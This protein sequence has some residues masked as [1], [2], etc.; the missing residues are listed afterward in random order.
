[1]RHFIRNLVG[2]AAMVCL[3]PSA[4]ALV[5]NF[6]DLSGSDFFTA[7]YQGFTFAAY[8]ADR[9][10]PCPQC[11]GSWFWSDANPEPVSFASS[12]NTSL[13]TDY[14]FDAPIDVSNSMSITSATQFYF[15]GAKFTAFDDGV[16][17]QF[18]LKLNGNIVGAGL[19]PS[20][21][22]NYQQAPVFV[23]SG[24]NGLV[25]EVQVASQD[26]YFAM[27]DFTY[28]ISPVPEPSAWLMMMAG[29][30]AVG[31]RARRAKSTR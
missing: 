2:A 25:D 27:D 14:D 18:V 7:P 6:D 10:D 31:L 15:Q 9:T 20:V 17:V 28:S 4:S 12:G 1:M 8:T 19:S 16:P 11:R 30:G 24:Y 21:N 13:S 3:A 5:L 23:S 29:L 22:L 26:G